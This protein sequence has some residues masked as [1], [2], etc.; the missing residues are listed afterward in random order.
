MGQTRVLIMDGHS[1]HY[2][3]ELLE[4]CIS[5]NI[6]V[7]CYPAHCTH[8]LQGLDVVCFAKMKRIWHA[9]LDGFLDENKRGINKE[10]FAEV[11]GHAYNQA[12]EAETI[13]AA[14]RVTGVHPFDPM[15]ITAQQMKPSEVSSSRTTF[16]LPLPSPVRR[17]MAVFRHQQSTEPNRDETHEHMDSPIASSS[18]TILETPPSSPSSQRGAC[19]D[20]ELFTPSKRMQL[21]NKT[22]LA[23]QTG[24]FLVSKPTSESPWIPLQPVFETA[25]PELPEPAWKL[26]ADYCDNLSQLSRSSLESHIE[27]LTGTLALA[28]THV[29]IQRSINE[30]GNA[31]LAVQQMQAE[32]MNAALLQ[33]PKKR[34]RNRA[35]FNSDGLGRVATKAEVIIE[36]KKDEED[37]QRKE[38]EKAARLAVRE[39]RRKAKAAIEKEWL[40]M[41]SEHTSLLKRWTQETM[42]LKGERVPRSQWPL[43]PKL[44]KKPQQPELAAVLN[45]SSEDSEGDDDSDNHL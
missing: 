18:H 29:Y 22:I 7:L 3:L 33:R 34:T 43:R 6:V 27:A 23:S 44:S 13:Q 40:R 8:A 1:S 25:P 36:L 37:T 15:V 11:F 12:F 41:K 21:F 24:S 19:I 28:Q 38:T 16:P 4:F 14:F 45:E 10:D 5:K 31:Q 30:A 2:S 20:P 26:A 39:A 32:R 17:L 42:S 35:K 9:A